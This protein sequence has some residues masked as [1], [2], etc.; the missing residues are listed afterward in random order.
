VLDGAGRGSAHV[1]ASLV[2]RA[3][4]LLID[5]ALRWGKPGGRIDVDAGVRG[6]VIAIRVRHDSCVL[7]EQARAKAFI[8]QGENAAPG[9]IG[10]S[11]YYA[12]CVAAAHGGK[13][14]L[15]SQPAELTIELPK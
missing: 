1:D 9:A 15:K 13:L 12:H 5:A 10:L 6:D 11:L 4:E 14:V 2:T 7:G 3:L 8:D